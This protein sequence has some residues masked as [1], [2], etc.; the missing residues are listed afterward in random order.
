MNLGSSGFFPIL[1]PFCKEL[2][3]EC[4]CERVCLWKREEAWPLPDWTGWGVY[5]YMYMC[6]H[7][8]V[9]VCTSVSM[10]YACKSFPQ[11]IYDFRHFACLFNKTIPFVFI[12]IWQSAQLWIIVA[13]MVFIF[14]FVSIAFLVYC[15]TLPA[16]KSI[17]EVGCWCWGWLRMACISPIKSHMNHH[18]LDE[19][20]PYTKYTHKHSHFP[21]IF[22]LSP[23]VCMFHHNLPINSQQMHF[24][25]STFSRNKLESI[26]LMAIRLQQNGFTKIIQ[27]LHILLN[28]A[29]ISWSHYVSKK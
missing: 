2:R 1:L 14:A 5:L 24:K 19:M 13:V 3:C 9:Y 29:S 25:S 4:A 16:L 12:L 17:L 8:N 15:T 10:V 21:L 20:N 22:A 11:I 7:I 27:N 28:N 6:S 23:S 18:N 26:Q